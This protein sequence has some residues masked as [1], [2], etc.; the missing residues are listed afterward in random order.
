MSER[1][2]QIIKKLNQKSYLFLGTKFFI[3]S[4]KLFC[5]KKIKN[6]KVKKIF[7]FFG[8]SDT[9]NETLKIAKI[10]K[11]FNKLDFNILIGGLNRNYKKIR[12]YCNNIKNI[13]IYHNLNN[14]KVFNLMSKNDI[15]IRPVV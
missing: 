2:K 12:N 7:V 15:S 3:S 14:D 11:L 5:Q 6:N 8:S 1:S 10:A 9:S 13:K 4:K